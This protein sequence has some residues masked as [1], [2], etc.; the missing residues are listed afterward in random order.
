MGRK[1]SRQVEGSWQPR[2]AM[3]TG[4]ALILLRLFRLNYLSRAP[5]VTAFNVNKEH[6]RFPGQDSD[7]LFNNEMEP[8]IIS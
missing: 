3:T 1:L 4:W 6:R 7:V 2:G 8:C 5:S